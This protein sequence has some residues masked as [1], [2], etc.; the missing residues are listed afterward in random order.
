[1]QVKVKDRELLYKKNPQLK[2]G[3]RI[4]M[5]TKNFGIKRLSKKLDYVKVGPFLIT[6]QTGPVNYRVVLLSDTRKH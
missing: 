2:E 5:L 6:K 3:D 1:M 4:Y